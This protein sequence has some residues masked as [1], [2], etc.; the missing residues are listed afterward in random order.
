MMNG[1]LCSLMLFHSVASNLGAALLQE[2]YKLDLEMEK[3]SLAV[4]LSSIF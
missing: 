1:S 4:T 3:E 2:Q